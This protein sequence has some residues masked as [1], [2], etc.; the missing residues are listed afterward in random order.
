[1]NQASNNWLLERKDPGDHQHHIKLDDGF[2]YKNHENSFE[3]KIK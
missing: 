3:D 2:N 1:M